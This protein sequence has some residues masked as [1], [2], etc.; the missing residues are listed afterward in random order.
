MRPIMTQRG[1]LDRM[2]AEMLRSGRN[3]M[4]A[5]IAEV[6]L[7]MRSSGSSP[8]RLIRAMIGADSRFV[9]EGVDAWAARRQDRRTLER[10]L[11][12]LA[13]VEGCEKPGP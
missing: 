13:W 11:W 4:A 12:L 7:K 6:F 1:L 8:G 10:Q 3:W 5:E 2:H 9:E